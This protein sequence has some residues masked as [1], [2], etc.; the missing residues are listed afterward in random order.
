MPHRAKAA[1]T[2]AL[3]RLEG[4]YGRLVTSE[5]PVE[6]G[7]MTL[8][9]VHDPARSKPETR[10]LLR[11]AFVDWNEA[12]VSDPWDIVTAIGAG[13]DPAAREF[14]RAAIRFLESLNTVL[15]R[16]SLDAVAADPQTDVDAV[17]EKLRGATPEVRAVVRA[18]MDKEGGWHPGAEMVKALQKIGVVGKTTSAAKAGKEAQDAGDASD[19][20]RAHYLLTRYGCRPKEEDDPLETAR[21]GKGGEKKAAGAK[22]KSA[23]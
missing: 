18:T 2:D 1:L 5:D 16:T 21:R 7:L 23:K 13:D 10:D 3:D 19:R 14:A 6:A 15:H 20:M 8:L 4:R 22:A 17:L 11:A 9:A 12:R